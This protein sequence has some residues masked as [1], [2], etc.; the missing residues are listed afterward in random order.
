MKTC[1]LFAL[2]TTDLQELTDFTAN[3]SRCAVSQWVSLPSLHSTYTSKS[4]AQYIEDWILAESW[5]VQGFVV[6]PL[7]SFPCSVSI[8]APRVYKAQN[9]SCK[10]YVCVVGWLHA[11]YPQNVVFFILQDFG[12]DQKTVILYAVKGL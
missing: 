1:F 7:F 10:N 5:G 4:H 6:L 2:G 9:I 8:C 11:Y 3:F 12:E